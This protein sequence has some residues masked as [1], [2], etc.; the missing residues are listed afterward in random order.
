MAVR[1]PEEVED[2]EEDFAGLMGRL[3]LAPPCLLCVCALLCVC[4]PLSC[5]CSALFTLL[6]TLFF[7]LLFTFVCPCVRACQCVC[8]CVG[9]TTVCGMAGAEGGGGG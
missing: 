4:S 5:V 7:T 3:V 8:V 2:D 6:F 1:E 9:V